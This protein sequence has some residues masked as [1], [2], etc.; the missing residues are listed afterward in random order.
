MKNLIY[1]VPVTLALIAGF[2]I[3]SKN[4]ESAYAYAK[5]QG[6]FQVVEVFAKNGYSPAITEAKAGVPT[7]LKI[8]TNNTLDCSAALFIPSIKYQKYLPVTGETEVQLLPQEK[9][10]T[11]S[12]SCSMGMFGFEIRFV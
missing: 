6:N 9:G 8:K 3:V 2:L 12:A 11:V 4:S 5:T 7:I 1:L 10:A